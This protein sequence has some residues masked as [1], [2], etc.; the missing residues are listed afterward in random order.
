[1][2]QNSL[3]DGWVSH[4]LRLS[5]TARKVELLIR[6][7]K[8]LA[9]LQQD[10]IDNGPVETGAAAGSTSRAVREQRPGDKS[11]GFKIGNEAGDS[12]WQLTGINEWDPE[13]KVIVLGIANPMWDRYYKFVE[14]GFTH[15]RTKKSIP[16]RFFVKQAL[17]RHMARGY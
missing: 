5:I 8:E 10:L 15:H 6:V 4:R 1:M 17:N 7:Q 2:P 13:M 11:Y 3:A 12:G 16:A 9:V 14:L